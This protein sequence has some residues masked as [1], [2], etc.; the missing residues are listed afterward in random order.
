MKKQSAVCAVALLILATL[1]LVGCDSAVNY[2]Q[3]LAGRSFA[4]RGWI[5]VASERIQVGSSYKQL[6]VNM[7]LS[8]S[9]NSFTCKTTYSIPDDWT[10]EEKKDAETIGKALNF[11]GTYTYNLG[12]VEL[13]FN[14]ANQNVTMTAHGQHASVQ[15][16]SAIAF[17]DLPLPG[18]GMVSFMEPEIAKK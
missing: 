4:T 3:N 8:F 7:V 15:G 9:E 1:V 16:A 6:P 14:P 13:K 5:K 17:Q 12:L 2:T 10:P 18:S 11:S